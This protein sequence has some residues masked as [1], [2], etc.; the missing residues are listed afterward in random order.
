MATTKPSKQRIRFM[1]KNA[2]DKNIGDSVRQWYIDELRK[3][4]LRP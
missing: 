1:R 4:G 2:K 3:Y